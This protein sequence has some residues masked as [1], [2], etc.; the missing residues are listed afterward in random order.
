MKN[1]NVTLTTHTTKE[2][3][4]DYIGHPCI[5]N[6]R[7]LAKQEMINKPVKNGGICGKCMFREALETFMVGNPE[8]SVKIHESLVSGIS[9]DAWPLR[10][11]YG[12]FSPRAAWRF[13]R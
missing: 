5:S 13:W 4:I 1:E 12:P 8:G 7:R 6:W 10:L 2:D 9:I 11:L 3:L